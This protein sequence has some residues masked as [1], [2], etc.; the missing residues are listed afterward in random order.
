MVAYQWRA[1]GS[2]ADAVPDGVSNASGT[3]HDIPSQGTCNFCHANMMD[4][5]LGITALQLSHDLPGLKLT[6][7]ITEGRLTTPPAAPFALPGSALAQDALGYLHANCGHCHN[8][9]SRVAVSVSL[10]LWESTQALDSVETTVG[11][12]SAVGQPNMFLPSLHIIEPGRPAQSELVYR[13]SR[14]GGGQ[15]PPAGTELVD[16]VG[17]KVVT[18]WIASLPKAPDAGVPDGGA[19]DAAVVPHDAATGG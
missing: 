7:L 16:D 18:D 19:P 8:P 4:T 13:I 3:Q 12:E 10:R 2:D 9:N 5:L 1:D 11:Y 15:M 17:M 6:D 14:R